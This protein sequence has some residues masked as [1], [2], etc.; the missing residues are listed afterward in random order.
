MYTDKKL[1]TI[2]ATQNE[3]INN[4]LKAIRTFICKD[5]QDGGITLD[6]VKNR[7]CV[8]SHYLAFFYHKMAD[9]SKKHFFH[10]FPITEIIYLH[11]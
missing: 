8:A 6:M 5:R 2:K 4:V 9:T 1:N 10:C 3:Q 7:S 11:D